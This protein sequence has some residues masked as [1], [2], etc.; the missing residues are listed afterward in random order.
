MAA[1]LFSTT[2]DLRDKLQ[3]AGQATQERLW[4]LPLWDDYQK[5]IESDVADMKNSGGRMGGVATSAIFLKQFVDFDNWAHLDIASMA[6][7]EKQR[8]YVTR[9][10]TGFGSRLLVEF[11]RNWSE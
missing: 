7:A 9:G 8:G 10:G 3:V 6:F 1:G 11:L 5:A 2:D 4:P